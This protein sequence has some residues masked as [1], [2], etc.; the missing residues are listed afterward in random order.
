[1]ET[2]ICWSTAVFISLVMFSTLSVES[3]EHLM[4]LVDA[5]CKIFP[6]L[7]RCYKKKFAC[8]IFPFLVTLLSVVFCYQYDTLLLMFHSS[9]HKSTPV[10]SVKFLSADQDSKNVS[11]TS[12]EGMYFV[13]KKSLMFFPCGHFSISKCWTWTR[14]Y[15]SASNL[16]RLAAHP[17]CKSVRG[18]WILQMQGHLEV[19]FYPEDGSKQWCLIAFISSNFLGKRTMS[20]LDV[21][22]V[23]IILKYNE[24]WESGVK[25]ISWNR[26]ACIKGSGLFWLLSSGY[27]S[28]SFNSL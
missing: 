5:Y 26:F 27:N 21:W 28:G 4:R 22:F 9:F 7:L 12:A 16:Q 6:R 20:L 8:G 10:L 3:D 18:F 11:F 14:L 17:T 2:E 23:I 15:G 25:S 24:I 19:N 13:L 1:M